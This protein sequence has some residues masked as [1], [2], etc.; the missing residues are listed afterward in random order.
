MKKDRTGGSHYQAWPGTCRNHSHGAAGLWP[1][2]E[3]VDFV[4][5]MLCMLGNKPWWREGEQIVGS[6]VHEGE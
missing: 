6:E 4:S 3:R 1:P 2:P 5:G